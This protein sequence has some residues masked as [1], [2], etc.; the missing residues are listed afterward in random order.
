MRSQP[1]PRRILGGGGFFTAIAIGLA[2]SVGLGYVLEW[3]FVSFLYERE[4]L[5]QVLMTYGLILGFEELRSL[6]FGDDVHGVTPPAWLAGMGPEG[7][8]RMLDLLASLRE[9]HAILLIEHDIDAVFRI[10]DRIT[11][12]VDGAAIA[13][14]A[15]EAIGNDPEVQTAYLG[16]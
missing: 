2:L 1:G 10:A 14:G 15:P 4:Q 11:V 5:Q 13:S 12:M 3:E 9:E 7:T 8:E 16:T 6:A